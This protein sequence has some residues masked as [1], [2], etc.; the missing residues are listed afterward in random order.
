MKH[1]YNKKIKYNSS[2]QERK[3]LRMN[4]MTDMMNMKNVIKEEM[5]NYYFW[6]IIIINSD[7][8]NDMI[9]EF[10]DEIEY[11]YDDDYMNI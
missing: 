10:S 1:S 6:D 11:D 3:K 4:N 9:Y 8:D 2:N 5:S 7:Y